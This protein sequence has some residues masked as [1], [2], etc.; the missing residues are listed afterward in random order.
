MKTL[1]VWVTDTANAQQLVQIARAA[2]RKKIDL[3]IHLT[4][5]GVLLCST[6]DIVVLCRFCRCVTV[7]RESAQTHNIRDCIEA[8]KGVAAISCS[9]AAQTLANCDRRLM[10]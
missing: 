4:G 5:H 6:P 10:L 7:C 3:K 1:C 2:H 9:Q 8:T